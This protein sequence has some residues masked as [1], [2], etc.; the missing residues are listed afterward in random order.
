MYAHCNN[1]FFCKLF[2]GKTARSFFMIKAKEKVITAESV[3]EGHPDKLC[4]FISDAILDECLKQD[5]CARVACEVLAT[6][7]LVVIAGEITT[8]A[9]VNYSEVAKRVI[10]EVGYSTKDIQFLEKVQTQSPDIANSV[11]TSFEVREQK[12]KQQL[13]QQGAGD[14]GIMYGY[15]TNETPE[16][17]PLPTILSA[18]LTRQL[19]KVRKNK[20]IVGLLPDG[21]SQVSVVYINDVPSYV[22]SV[23]VSTQHEENVCLEM[24]RKEVLE[25]V[26]KPVLGHFLTSQTQVLINPSGRFVLGGAQAD[27]GLTGRKIIVDTY[28][29][30]GRHGG[31]AFS[32]KDASKV[33][34]SAAYMMRYIAKNLVASGVCSKCE[35][36]VAYAI[37]KAKPTSVEVTSFGTG[38]VN[39]EFL[40]QVVLQLF[41][42]TPKAIIKNLNLTEPIF[43]T[44]ASGGHFGRS[45]FSWENLD[46]VEAIKQVL[47]EYKTTRFHI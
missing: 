43:Q 3:T 40:K 29:G 32:G 36:N 9:K 27:T 18:K 2:V 13:L 39:D 42:L 15:A 4:D 23:V 34:R 37:G 16:L 45:E 8:K 28:G 30:V 11:N 26:I 1:G 20:Q 22:S 12:S 24:L 33:D 38:I 21:K 25:H 7:N 31:G 10:E 5:R 19:T 41:D 14:Q 46:K 35:V 17:M 6:A 44:T 47:K